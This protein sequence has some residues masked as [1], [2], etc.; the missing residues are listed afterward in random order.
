MLRFY[1]F[2]RLLCI[3]YLSKDELLITEVKIYFFLN[4]L[5]LLYFILAM[6]HKFLSNL[7][8]FFTN[9]WTTKIQCNQT[10]L[11]YITMCNVIIY[12]FIMFK[13]FNYLVSYN[14]WLM[15]HPIN[16]YFYHRYE[17]YARKF[18]FPTKLQ[19]QSKQLQ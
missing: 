2:S 1:D 8:S 7:T 16:I 14:L 3:L 10:F 15:L 11:K 19:L 6:L 13:L 12:L 5:E 18:W 17:L 9:N 4:I